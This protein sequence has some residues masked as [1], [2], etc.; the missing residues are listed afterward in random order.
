MHEYKLYS[1][2][3]EQLS[4]A[5]LFL[6]NHSFKPYPSPNEHVQEQSSGQFSPGKTDLSSRL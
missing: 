3:L 5:Q 4:M 6:G 2:E 1:S